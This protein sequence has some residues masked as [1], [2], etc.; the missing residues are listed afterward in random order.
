VAH[1]LDLFA[2]FFNCSNGFQLLLHGMLLVG[3]VFASTGLTLWNL[4]AIRELL[5][6][7]AE[8]SLTA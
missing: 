8:S 7:V 2:I 6:R 3:L 1:N 4:V 5:A